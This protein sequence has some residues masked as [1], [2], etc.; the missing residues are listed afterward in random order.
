VD[1]W[2]PIATGAGNLALKATEEAG[3]EMGGRACV[4][5]CLWHIADVPHAPTNVRYR[6]QSG[7]DANGPLCRLMTQSRLL[8]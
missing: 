5:V 3:R 2:C 7:H 6:G 4:N 1:S 8:R